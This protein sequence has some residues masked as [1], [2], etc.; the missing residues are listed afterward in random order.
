MKRLIL[1]IYLIFSL[2]T[3]SQNCNGE[4]LNNSEITGTAAFCSDTGIT[5]CNSLADGSSNP[6]KEAALGP[7]YSCLESRPYP[8]WFFIRVNKTGILNLTIEQKNLSDDPIDVD[9]IIWGP[10]TETEI[11]N[12]KG[13][14][15]SILKDNNVKDCSYAIDSVEFLSVNAVQDRE[16]YVILVTNFEEE[17]GTISMNSTNPNDV[18]NAQTDCSIISSTLGP[19]RKV[20]DG[21]EIMLDGT[22]PNNSNIN[23]KWFV[24]TGSGYTEISGE[25]NATLTINNNISGTY[26]VEI[27]D[28]SGGM[29]N[30]EVKIIYFPKPV[31]NNINDIFHCDTD[32]DGFNT[33]NL[34]NLITPTILNGQDANQFEVVYYSNIDDA[35]ANVSGNAL[36]NNFTNQIAFNTSNFF[37]RIHNKNAPTACYEVTQFKITIIAEP[38]VVQPSD[39]IVCDDILSGSDTDGIFSSFDL[40]SKDAE[41]LD[42]L[43]STEFSVTYHT[44]LAGAQTNAIT[45]V[46]DK[47]SLFVNTIPNSQ[48]IYVRVE[49]NVNVN[50]NVVSDPNSSNFKPFDLIINKLPTVT[51]NIDFKQCDIDTDLITAINLTKIEEII[52][53]N[54]A[55]ESFKYYLNQSDADND[56]NQIVTPENFNA[57]NGQ[58]IWVK[59]INNYQCHRISM[60]NII[61]SHTNN[62]VYNKQF[63]ECDD[64][65]TAD[66]DNIANSNNN[67]D[68]ITNF[69]LSSVISDVKALFPTNLQTNLDVLIFENIADRNILKNPILNLSNYRNKNIPALSPQPLFIKIINSFNNECVGLGEFSILTGIPNVNE[70]TPIIL[71]DDQDSGSSSDGQNIGI[72]LRSKISE[73]V[74]SQNANDFEITFH[75]SFNEALTAQNPIN[76]DTSFKNTV[77][78]N[79]RPGEVS[80]QTVYVAVKNKVTGC[81]NA[82]TKL[83]IK[84]NP[85]PELLT[86]ITPIKLCDSGVKDNDRRN[87]LEQNI[88]LSQKYNEILN[89][90]N[91]TDFNISFHKTKLDSYSGNN[92]ISTVY[93]MDENNTNIINNIGEEIVWIRIQNKITGCVS[94]GTQLIL[95]VFPEIILP[96]N[97]TNYIDC[98]NDNNGTTSDTDGVIGN[99]N[100]NTKIS[101]I[102][103][104]YDV[105]EFSNFN[106]SFHNSLNEANTNSNPINNSTYTNLRTPQDI[107]VRVENKRS[108]CFNTNVNFQIIINPLPYFEVSSPQTIC[109]NNPLLTITAESPLSND[110]QY[111]W[112]NDRN[113]NIILGNNSSI[114]I[115]NGGNYIVTA[116][117]RNTNCKRSLLIQVNES[118]EPSILTNDIIVTDDTNNNGSNKYAIAINNSNNNLGIGDYEFALENEDGETIPYQDKPEFKELQ[119]GIYTLFV[120]DKNGC[121]MGTLEIPLVEFP[122]FFT[123]NQDGFNDKWMVKG[124]NQSYFSEALITIYDRFG[125]IIIK[126]DIN[127]D[128]GWDGNYNGQLQPSNDYWFEVILTDNKNKTYINSG[129]FSLIRK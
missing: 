7:S 89:G 14:D 6:S 59:T 2:N 26:K 10:Y 91:S 65:L 105:S 96:T 72:N 24:N 115:S 94:A 56:I 128:N 69:N 36:S 37:A 27:T 86:S 129:H 1:V 73:L 92:S 66:G 63:Y 71:C 61:I 22:P 78:P 97:I 35:N 29:G 98:D 34:Q 127:K 122:K 45:D 25:T 77:S 84:I 47:N 70:I 21:T 51:P 53:Q 102:L 118:N 9:F 58:T 54:W 109:M 75:I 114:D 39:Y 120:Q 93:D 124:V 95:R 74:D 119:G 57:V 33:F 44:T 43:P 18:N 107:F 15:Y 42:S 31:A 19:D 125:K 12:I 80:E 32:G 101:E 28:D 23:Y 64:F 38:A 112:I 11:D 113:P 111:E 4:T 85:V 79:F 99:I 30:D 100:L 117:N 108:G 8:S 50:C 20:C 121:G 62:V 60:I 17:G 116:K 48:K 126:Q 13:G 110:Y 83:K 55:Q 87:G 49:N 76:N 106:V 67:M 5:F 82:N 123:P 46:I 104:N 103:L 52:S 81:I 16:Y 41:I 90:R 40:T 68:G 88:N 3:F